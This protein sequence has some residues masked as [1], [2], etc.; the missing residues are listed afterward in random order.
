[1]PLESFY[2]A[3]STLYFT[4]LGFWW[5]VVQLKRERWIANPATRRMAYAVSLNFFVPGVM[6][7][8]ALLSAEANF[9]WNVSF[10]LA[11]LLGAAASVLTATSLSSG[12]GASQNSVIGHW[13]AVALYALIAVIAA[14]PEI[15]TSVFSGVS[16]LLVEG[17]LLVLLA[18]LGINM[19]WFLFMEPD[20]E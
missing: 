3:A 14:I 18:L 4:L 5:V 13:G 15:I 7:I 10:V 20:A 1:M 17:V 19:A 9:V 2:T 12:G 11:G 8:T 6:C 16:A